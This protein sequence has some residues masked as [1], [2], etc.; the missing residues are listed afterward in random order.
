MQ[1]F[2]GIPDLGV[3][4]IILTFLVLCYYLFRFF[5]DSVGFKKF[6]YNFNK[7]KPVPIKPKCIEPKVTLIDENKPNDM[8]TK[9]VNE[10]VK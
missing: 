9:D 6:F 7:S 1:K 2:H 4:G 10:T 3:T 8:R 5:G